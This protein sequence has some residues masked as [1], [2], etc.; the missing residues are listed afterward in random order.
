MKAVRLNHETL[1][2]VARE[3]TPVTMETIRQFYDA[4]A[5]HEEI[6]IY[7]IVPR[8]EGTQTTP[9]R[10]NTGETFFSKFILVTTEGDW[11]N[12][13]NDWFEIRLKE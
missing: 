4:I 2:K 6:E 1:D 10:I 11:N 8:L 12:Y 9:L 13:P 5:P 3:I 7:I